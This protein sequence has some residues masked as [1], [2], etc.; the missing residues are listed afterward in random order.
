MNLQQ[1]Q[2]ATELGKSSDSHFNPL[3][4]WR[5]LELFKGTGF[6][7]KLNNLFSLN[8][9]KLS[10]QAKKKNSWYRPKDFVG[11][12]IWPSKSS[13]SESLHPKKA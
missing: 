10:Y 7:G 12:G 13:S 5:K 6:E 4:G 3:F 2:K 9:Q 1:E 11:K 8:S